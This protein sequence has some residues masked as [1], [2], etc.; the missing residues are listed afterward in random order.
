MDSVGG[1]A[2]ES[3]LAVPLVGSF[4]FVFVSGTGVVTDTAATTAGGVLD[5]VDEDAAGL[6][7]LVGECGD[8]LEG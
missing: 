1:K 7:V 2:G 3:L 5:I 8:G 4:V 6:E